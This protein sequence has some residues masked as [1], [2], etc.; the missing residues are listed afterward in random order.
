MILGIKLADLIIGAVVLAVIV[1]AVLV[2]IKKRKN[3][4]CN[5]GCDCG[6]CNKADKKKKE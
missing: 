3:G 1:I 6:C 2:L 5:C 4:S